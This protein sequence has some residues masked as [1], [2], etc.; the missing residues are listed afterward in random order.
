[1]LDLVARD[2]V[3]ADIARR[4]FLSTQTVQ[5]DVSAALGKLG[6]TSRAEAV[7]RPA[8]RASAVEPDGPPTVAI[9]RPPPRR[10]GGRGAAGGRPVRSRAIPSSGAR[11][12]RRRLGGA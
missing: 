3:N 11:T 4:L 7:A 10:P 1:M 9:D 6:V 12:R 2:P 5:N 8:T